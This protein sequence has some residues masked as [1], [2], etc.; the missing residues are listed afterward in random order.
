[1]PEACC[2]TA[3]GQVSR[4]SPAAGMMTICDQCSPIG[5]LRCSVECLECIAF[6]D[7]PTRH[8]E[9]SADRREGVC[10]RYTTQM[11]PAEISVLIVGGGGSGL[12][13]SIL[14]SDLGVDSL[15]IERRPGT[16]H[17]PKAGAHNQRT[18]EIFRRHGIADQIQ[19]M[20][21]PAE[22]RIRASWLTS[23]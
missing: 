20:G 22:T 13:S 8:R 9:G 10:E 7:P 19:A 12:S 23:L 17:M 14:L 5:I 16:S 3:R 15:L 2:M 1:A 21:A 4:A 6:N 11:L 18:M